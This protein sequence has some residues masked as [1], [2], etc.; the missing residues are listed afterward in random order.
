MKKRFLLVLSFVQLCCVSCDQSADTTN[1][2]RVKKLETE[3]VQL[4]AKVDKL[5]SEMMGLHMALDSVKNQNSSAVFDPSSKGYQR[6]DTSSG[7]FL[8]SLKDIQ[9]Y[10]DGYRLKLSIG[11]PSSAEYSGFSLTAKWHKSF[12]KMTSE[13]WQKEQPEKTFTYTE[14]LF[15]GSWN[16][17]SLI[18][19]PAQKE[20]LGYIEISMSTDQV[21]LTAH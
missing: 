7:S 12:E 4:K 14:K 21:M 9:P 6:V 8:V 20:E 3:Q 16:T 10:A 19:S 2:E 11:N 15:P 13:D 5:D 18:L 17:V 1:S